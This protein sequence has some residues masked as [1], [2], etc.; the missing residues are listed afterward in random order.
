[1]IYNT[2]KHTFTQTCKTL[3]K[4]SKIRINLTISLR[5]PCNALCG[6]NAVATMRQ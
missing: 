2:L 5:A 3:R 1:M 6:D 4:F